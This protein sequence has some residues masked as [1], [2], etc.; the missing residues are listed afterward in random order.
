MHAVAVIT[1][2]HLYLYLYGQYV[3]KLLFRIFVSVGHLE[4]Y[5]KFLTSCR[6]YD[7]DLYN[8]SKFGS[9]ILFLAF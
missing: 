2:L 9:K 8:C 4:L 6:F 3:A 7:M 5:R 1:Y